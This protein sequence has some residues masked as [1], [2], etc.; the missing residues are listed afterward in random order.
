M[1]SASQI[2]TALSAA[3][4]RSTRPNGWLLVGVCAHWGF[5]TNNSIEPGS[6]SN[7]E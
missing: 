3:A 4:L 5:G 6:K 7:P 1:R 2:A